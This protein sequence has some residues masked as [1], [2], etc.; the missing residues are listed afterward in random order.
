MGLEI[1]SARQKTTRAFKRDL[2]NSKQTTERVPFPWKWEIEMGNGNGKWTHVKRH[3][4]HSKET[5]KRVP[6]PWKW[7]KGNG[8]WE[9]L[10]VSF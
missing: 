8:E 2:E 4:E 6:C 3:L 10:V 7:E 5:T 1:A 9:V